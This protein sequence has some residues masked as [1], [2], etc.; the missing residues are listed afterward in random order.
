MSPRQPTALTK[1][2]VTGGAAV[3]M[4]SREPAD[5]GIPIRGSIDVN[6][7]PSNVTELQSVVI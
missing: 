4:V 6:D 7:S 1:G 2:Q 5:E 3:S